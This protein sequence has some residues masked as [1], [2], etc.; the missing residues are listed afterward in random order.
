MDTEGDAGN[1]TEDDPGNRAGEGDAAS[2]TQDAIMGATYRA[3]CEH[4]YANLTM[5]DIADEFDKSRSLLH[6]H[7]DTKEDLLLA[8]VEQ[9]VGWIGDRLAETETEDP[10]PRLEEYVDRFVIEPGE[11]D[12]QTFALAIIELRVQAVH[13]PQFR[14]KLRSHY[15]RNVE[16]VAEIL[17]DGIEAGVFRDVDPERVGE[18]IYTA[19]VGA[20]TY[21]V[22]L[23]AEDA[24]RRMRDAIAEFV[25][26]DLLVADRDVAE[27]AG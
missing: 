23:G 17:A 20:R 9:M 26:T 19:M 10:L 22:T 24:T 16:T 4:G 1:S 13:H 8:F 3:L 6:Y 7:Y 5:Q 27:Y 12:R 18:A 11:S 2:D 21:Q 25:A 15:E 14:E